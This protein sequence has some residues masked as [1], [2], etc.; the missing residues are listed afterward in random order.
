MRA[1]LAVLLAV[2]ALARGSSQRRAMLLEAQ[3][4]AGS[5]GR[6]AFA[7]AVA[8]PINIGTSVLLVGSFGLVGV[9]LGLLVF[10]WS[11]RLFGDG[12]GLLSL[13]LFATSP[14]LLAHGRMLTSDMSAA[15]GLLGC[16]ALLWWLL[17]RP[18]APRVLICG[19]AVGALLTCKLSGVLVVPIAVVLVVVRVV[20][21]PRLRR[22]AP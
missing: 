19:L 14:T 7:A 22:P 11:R 16:A 1:P 8:V 20:V 18:S 3:L 13:A 4:R 6:R 2:C 10:A 21:G 9:A 15:L 12:G 17:Q 5:S